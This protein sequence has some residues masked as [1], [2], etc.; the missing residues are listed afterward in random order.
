MSLLLSGLALFLATHLIPVFPAFRE[1]LLRRLKLRLYKALFSLISLSAIVLI[2]FGLQVAPFEPVFTPPNWG[3]HAAM[4]VML[5]AVYL[6]LSN[7]VGPAHSSA[8]AITAHPLSWGV[9]LWSTGHMLANG[10]L[11]HLLL[12][13]TFCLFSLVSIR[14]GRSRGLKPKLQH[15]PSLTEEAVFAGIVLIVYCA[16]LVGHPYFTGQPLIAF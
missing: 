12:F 9:I 8:Q 4:L 15:R 7:S 5:P 16:L 6:F 2:V 3:R 11:A 1:Q 13:G 10:D 14:S